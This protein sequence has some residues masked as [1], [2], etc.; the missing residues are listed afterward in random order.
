ML[1]KSIA[2]FAVLLI[3]SGAYAVEA[4]AAPSVRQLGTGVSSSGAEKIISVLP[5]LPKS[6]SEATIALKSRTAKETE[7][8]ARIPVLS[9]IKTISSERIKQPIISG[10]SVQPGTSGGVSETAFNE[11]VGRV[12]ALETESQNAINGVTESGSGNYVSGVSVDNN[13]L[14]IEKTRVLYAPVRNEGSNTIVGDAE[15]WLVR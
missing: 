9:S 3:Y 2:F 7:D 15:I 8:T 6:N 11:V 13:K 5:S 10:G 12:Q 14:N 1:K 4:Y